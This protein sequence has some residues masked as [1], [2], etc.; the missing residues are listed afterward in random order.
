MNLKLLA[1]SNKIHPLSLRKLF[2][3]S[4]MTRYTNYSTIDEF[5][6]GGNFIINSHTEINPI[7]R[8]LN[9]YVKNTT[10]FSCWQDMVYKAGEEFIIKVLD[11]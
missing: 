9:S 6:K 7:R 2:T 11:L 4:F 1:E 3:Q 8:E 10:Q 5:L